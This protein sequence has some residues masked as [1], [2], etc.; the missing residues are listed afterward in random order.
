MISQP[1][2]A[3]QEVITCTHRWATYD[4]SD[5]RSLKLFKRRETQTPI[6]AVIFCLELPG[7][8]YPQ[9]NSSIYT[10]FLSQF[11][12]KPSWARPSNREPAVPQTFKSSGVDQKAITGVQ[13][14]ATLILSIGTRRGTMV[15]SPPALTWEKRFL[16]T[17]DFFF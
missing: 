12:E 4:I 6:P 11:P 17:F 2:I 16:F 9:G 14:R 15:R 1:R 10:G 7:P 8:K 3:M 5:M 13:A